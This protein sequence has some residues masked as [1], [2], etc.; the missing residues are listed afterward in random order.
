MELVK[1]NIIIILKILKP[2]DS[3]Q[4]MDHYRQQNKHNNYIKK[5]IIFQ[6]NR[7]IIDI[8]CRVE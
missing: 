4:N 7:Q 2:R 3:I 6:T 5:I 8:R 1:L